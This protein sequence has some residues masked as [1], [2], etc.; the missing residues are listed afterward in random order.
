M[1]HQPDAGD[2][3]EQFRQQGIGIADQA[4]EQVRGDGQAEFQCQQAQQWVEHAAG[5]R[6]ARAAAGAPSAV[7]GLPG[8]LRGAAVGWRFG[9]GA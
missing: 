8:V 2:V 4:A 6:R 3:G 7:P 9:G 5:Q 1:F